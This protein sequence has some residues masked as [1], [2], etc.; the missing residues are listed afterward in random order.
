MS[1][2]FRADGYTPDVSGPLTG[3]DPARRPGAPA[4][5][6]DPGLAIVLAG[7]GSVGIAWELG[8]LIS[9]AA[10]GVDLAS[11]D[12]IVGTSA[13]AIVGALLGSSVPL[14]ESGQRLLAVDPA[15]D[16]APIVAPSA[17]LM[18]EVNAHWPDERMSQAARA[19]LGRIAL[20][21]PTVPLEQWLARIA[22]TL[23]GEDWPASLVVTAV[24]AEDGAFRTF[25]ATSGVPL[26]AAVAA[27]CSIPGW[28]PPVPLDGRR[29]VDGGLR[30]TTNADVAGL[31]RRILVL[32]PFRTGGISR[33]RLVE[34]LE[35]ARAAG[36]RIEIILPDQAFLESTG[37]NLM[38]PRHVP[39]AGAV[40]LADGRAAAADV[41]N[42]LNAP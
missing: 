7:G 8:V 28:F 32:A 20:A 16:P 4:E 41:L 39:A 5:R 21:A 6:P 27:S 24:D 12:R 9:L 31:A 29:W 3:V 35:P 18:A 22:A 15:T 14:D 2:R 23:D 38:D 40:G 25:D 37:F 11:A 13:G 17:A 34:E 19:E 10:E 36:A 33:R 1:S 42:L 26:V 30:S